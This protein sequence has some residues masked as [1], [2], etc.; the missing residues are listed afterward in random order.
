MLNFD[1]ELCR[2]ESE[3]ESKLIVQY[4]LPKLGYAP[5]TWHQEVS[6][7][8]I[9]LDF[10]AFPQKVGYKLDL[11]SPLGLVLEAKNPQRNLDKHVR[12]LRHYLTSLNIP[13]GVLTNGK[14]LRIYAQEIDAVDLVFWCDGKDI[15]RRFEEIENLIGRKQLQAQLLIPQPESISP[16]ISPSPQV[17]SM[18]TIAVY[19]N[20]GGVGKTTISTNLAAAFSTKGYRVLLIDIDAQANSTFATGLVKFQFDE[21]DDLRDRNVCDL[22]TSGDTNFID[23]I[24]R[25]SQY[26]NDPEIDV[27]PAHINLIDK[28]GDLTTMMTSRT[29]LMAKLKRVENNYDLVIIDTPPS[30]DIYAEVALITADYLIIPSDLKPFANQGL[31]TVKEFLK[32]IDESRSTFGKQPIQ[33]L[34]VLASKISTNARFIQYT[35]PKQRAV[36]NTRYEMSLMDS[37]IYD[38]TALSESFNKTIVTGELESPDP[39]SIFKYADSNSN[40]QT[41]AMEFDILADEILTKIGLK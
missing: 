16:I 34:G 25:K 18:K 5:D 36:I 17:S 28:Q 13:Y 24:V 21:E 29:R 38:R 35:F 27:I 39:K 33:V 41:S 37:V 7:G 3:V 31:P 26:F 4:L 11:K 10:L 15:D 1:P 20:K 40:A 8:K 12:Q 32:G 6:F 30:R 9:R 23:D 19:H 14:E 2:N 22:L